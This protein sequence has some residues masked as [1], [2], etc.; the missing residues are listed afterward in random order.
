[1]AH[2]I[3]LPL[4]LRRA[5][6][7]NQMEKLRGWFPCEPNGWNR[8]KAAP[9][10]PSASGA[11]AKCA[12]LRCRR[13]IR[14]LRPLLRSSSLPGLARSLRCETPPALARGRLARRPEFPARQAA[15]K[16][17]RP[18]LQFREACGLLPIPRRSK[19]FFAG[20]A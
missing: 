8:P 9:A 20:D 4:S 5:R 10:N 12:I 11:R 6:N 15:R 17:L 1:M 14:A 7:A 16:A 2:F 3:E 19:R 18:R 13:Y